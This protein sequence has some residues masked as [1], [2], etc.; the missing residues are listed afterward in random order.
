MGCKGGPSASD[1]CGAGLGGV[2]GRE[3]DEDD[4]SDGVALVVI[5]P[6]RWVVPLRLA[7]PR[8]DLGAAART[9]AVAAEAAVVA[10][11]AWMCIGDGET[12]GGRRE[13][14]DGET[15][16]RRE[17]GDGRRGGDGMLYCESMGSVRMLDMGQCF[18]FASKS[19]GDPARPN[20]PPGR[21]GGGY[22][23]L[24]SGELG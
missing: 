10:L 20:V 2:Q 21:G 23:N 5:D 14:G 17:E 4:I 7:L 15:G 12:G 3:E 11:L 24:Q 9:A 16:G 13:E 22:C 6:V 18:L 8:L 19:L 1:R